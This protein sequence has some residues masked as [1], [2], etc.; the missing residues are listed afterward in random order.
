MGLASTG[1]HCVWKKFESRIVP[2]PVGGRCRLEEYVRV[3][4]QPWVLGTEY[5]RLR[6]VMPATGV[7]A[8]RFANASS[9]LGST[10][11][12]CGCST[13]TVR[14]RIRVR[15]SQKTQPQVA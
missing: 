8:T 7:A 1:A 9:A 2:L 12:I 10:F 11:S 3:A 5:C 13:G 4:D 14:P 15:N 6:A